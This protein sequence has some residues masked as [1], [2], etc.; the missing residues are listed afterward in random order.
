MLRKIHTIEY[1]KCLWLPC[2][3]VATQI[4][5]NFKKFCDSS[6]TERYEK[7]LDEVKKSLFFLI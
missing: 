3:F 7:C 6:A 2:N 1:K 5:D 4:F